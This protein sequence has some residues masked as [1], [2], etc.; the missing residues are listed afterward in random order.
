MLF[1]ATVGLDVTGL[2]THRNEFGYIKYLFLCSFPF[3]SLDVR[4]WHGDPGHVEGVRRRAPQ[5]RRGANPT[6]RSGEEIEKRARAAGVADE[7]R[8]MAAG[9]MLRACPPAWNEPSSERAL[10]H[11]A[12][13]GLEFGEHA[14][15]RARARGL[16]LR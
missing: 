13:C 4:I 1:R 8:A 10:A 2:N 9:C 15:G 11:V 14:C 5:W 12:A 6:A 16:F 7:W 3:P